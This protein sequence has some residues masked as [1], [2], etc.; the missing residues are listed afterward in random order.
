MTDRPPA[1]GPWW[2][3]V[4]EYLDERSRDEH[5]KALSQP[6]DP[7][8]DAQPEVPGLTDAQR[9]LLQGTDDQPAVPRLAHSHSVPDDQPSVP[10]FAHPACEP[11]TE[12]Q[13][14]ETPGTPT[15]T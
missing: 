8:A 6:A 13:G 4:E 1:R 15:G 2:R 3:L 9:A 14:D 7:W 10:R 12:A 5:D 11:S